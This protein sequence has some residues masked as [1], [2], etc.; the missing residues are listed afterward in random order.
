MITHVCSKVT[1][2]CREGWPQKNDLDGAIKPFWKVRGELTVNLLLYGKRIVI[3][4]TL[5]QETL[6]KV[7]Q[8]H[9]GIQRCR[10][11]ARVSIWWPGLSQQ[12]K[13]LIERCPKCVKEF[14]PQREPLMP[15]KLPDYPW[16]K[17]GSDLFML[18]GATYLV[19]VDYFS[20]YPEVVKLTSTTSHSVI[21]ALK[22]IFSRHG[23]PETMVSDNGPQYASQEFAEFAQLYDFTS[24]PYFPQSNGQAER[25]VQTLKKNLLNYST[26]KLT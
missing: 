4:Q 6:S 21:E 24:S 19:L 7:H 12:I 2:Y 25:T 8:G 22:P 15:T 18:K 20:R 9:Q 13:D 10:L 1:E 26:T 3:P 14:T 23:V 17:V 11:R 16:Q 5:R